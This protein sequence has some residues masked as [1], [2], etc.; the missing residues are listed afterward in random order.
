MCNILGIEIDMQA[1]K[2]CLPRDKLTRV[3]TMVC[4]W[5]GKKAARRRKRRKLESP[6]GLLQHAA[7]VVRPGRRFVKRMI[8]AMSTAKKRDHFVQLG[9]DVRSDLAW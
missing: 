2:L 3:Q 7:K 5:L 1:L 4:E 9:A 8:Q 6:L